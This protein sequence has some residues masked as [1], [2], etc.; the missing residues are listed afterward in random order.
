MA[1]P[2][3]LSQCPVIYSDFPLDLTGFF[4]AKLLIQFLADKMQD[5]RNFVLHYFILV[6]DAVKV[7][8][9]L[10]VTNVSNQEVTAKH[11][12]QTLEKT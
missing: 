2:L 9:R 4:S 11:K 6:F 10:Q 12:P 5:I 8:L 1:A 7:H 3:L